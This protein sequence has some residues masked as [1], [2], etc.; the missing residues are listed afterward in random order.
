MRKF[1]AAFALALL[2][3]AAS[4]A[5]MTV[6]TPVTGVTLYSNNYAFVT[7]EGAA[8]L[9]PGAVTL[10]IT[11]FTRS[12]VINAVSPS[13]SGRL[14]SEFYAY[15]REYNISANATSP[16]TLE[17]LLN[18]S[19]GRDVSFTIN[20]SQKSGRLLWF[21]SDRIGVASNGGVSLYRLSD[22]TQLTVPVQQLM[23]EQNETKREH[24]LALGV[25]PGA[26]GRSGV[27]LTY[28]VGGPSWA[29]HYKYYISSEGSSGTGALQGWANVMNNG[30]EDWENVTLRLVVG[31]P[32]LTLFYA[33][34]RNYDY[35]E[36]A[37]IAGAAPSPMAPQ[38][39]ASQVSAYYVYTLQAPAT[40]RDGESRNLPLLE[41]ETRYRREYFWDTSETMPEKV[42]FLNN[43]GDE[44]WAAGVFRVYL[45]GELLGEASADYTARNREAR[46]SVSDLPDIHTEKESLNQT[47]RDDGRS[48]TT[49]YEYRLAI[50]NTMGEDADLRINDR[51]VSGDAVALVSSTLPATQKPGHILEWNAHIA[52]GQKLEIG[53]VYE[54]TNYYQPRY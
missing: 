27:A 49:R 3:L 16:I 29:A 15:D 21:G 14:L 13:L 32:H 40:V 25:R 39:T 1:A 46:V 18:R 43:T 9:P 36:S 19:I 8:Q 6:S 12:A 35:A 28:L 52:K 34:Q 24:G 48:R 42:F 22:V 54:V 33:A 20:G 30:G 23:E 4:A 51:M 31:Y 17:R 45:N 50:E 26:E 53:Y 5:N 37:G 2:A 11:N 41:S 47:T 44:S 10:L 38:F 7:R